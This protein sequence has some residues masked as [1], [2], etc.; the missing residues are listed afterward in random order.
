MRWDQN[1]GA[2]TFSAVERRR[3]VSSMLFAFGIRRNASSPE[4]CNEGFLVE[5]DELEAFLLGPT[6]VTG[7]VNVLAKNA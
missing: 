6:D 5:V 7:S 4:G 2:T 1:R 3:I